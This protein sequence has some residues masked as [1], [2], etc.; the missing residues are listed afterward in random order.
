MDKNEFAK[1]NVNNMS[2]PVRLGHL[3]LEFNNNGSLTDDCLTEFF[4]K[5]KAIDTLVVR[6]LITDAN[7]N[8]QYL[9][10]KMD[11]CGVFCGSINVEVLV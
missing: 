8:L 7:E 11:S 9:K 6:G 5:V 4:Q 2:D 3:I 1:T 10:E